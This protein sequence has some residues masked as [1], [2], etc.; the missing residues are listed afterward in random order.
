MSVSTFLA[1]LRGGGARPNR[2]EVLIEFP[3]FA[4]GASTIQ[5]TPFLVNS[6]QLPGST[7]GVI[8]H[9]F[10]G[11]QVKLAGDRIY[12]EWEATF[13]N[14]TDFDIRNAFERWHNG[15]NTYRSNFGTV[16][17][18]YMS[19]VTAYQLDQQDRR[20]KTYSMLYAWPSVV[21]PIEVSQDTNDVLELFSVTFAYSDID[22]G[23]G[24]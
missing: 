6:S 1:N 3:A 2:F 8:E 23:Q 15:I 11:R 10:R 13:V 19:T 17:E 21:A 9:P 5:K 16:P 14:D 18:S 22:N 12:D 7:L 4:A 24:N 20:I